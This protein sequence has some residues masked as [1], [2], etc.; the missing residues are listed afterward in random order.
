MSVSSFNEWGKLKEIVVG[1]ATNANWPKTDPVFRSQSTSWTETP[2]PEG[3][4]P[5][6]VVDEANEDLEILVDILHQADV[7]VHRPMDIDFVG[8]DGMYN[9]CPRDRFDYCR[10]NCS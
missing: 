5:Q 1:T 6:W 4:V 10:R 9:Y 2:I 3:P 8:L 7:T